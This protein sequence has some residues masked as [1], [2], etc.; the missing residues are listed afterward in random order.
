MGFMTGNILLVLFFLLGLVPTFFILSPF[1]EWSLDNY[2]PHPVLYEIRLSPHT[3]DRIIHLGFLAMRQ[4]IGAF[5]P[6]HK[7]A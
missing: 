3:C 7:L 5:L 1:L 2:P 6:G 4:G